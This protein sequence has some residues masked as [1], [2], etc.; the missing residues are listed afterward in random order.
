MIHG[1]TPALDLL[2]SFLSTTVPQALLFMGPS[3][4]GK[5][6]LAIRFAS[7]FA[8]VPVQRIESGNSADVRVFEG[9]KLVVSQSRELETQLRWNPVAA[10]RRV[11]IIDSAHSMNS[12]VYNSLLKILEEP[13]PLSNLILISDSPDKIPLTV[14]SRCQ[15]VHFGILTTEALQTVLVE[16][17]GASIEEARSLS[18]VAEGSMERAMWAFKGAFRED[19]SIVHGLIQSLKAGNLEPIFI[20]VERWSDRSTVLRRLYLTYLYFR[21]TSIYRSNRLFALPAQDLSTKNVV[22][23]STRIQNSYDAISKNA[24][25]K[26]VLDNLFMDMASLLR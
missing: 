25:M 3:G 16:S 7:R 12:S 5:R 14:R 22:L 8:G 11:A 6:T 17:F 1:Q 15:T 13:P 23:I 20:E 18:A 19:I 9:G 2:E 10:L 24:N 26:L 4:V 21:D